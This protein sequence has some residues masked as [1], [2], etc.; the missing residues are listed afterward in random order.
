M[1]ADV[2]KGK[3]YFKDNDGNE[4][5]CDIH[6][7]RTNPDGTKIK[8]DQSDVNLQ[9]AD[10]FEVD[11]DKWDNT[12][13]PCIKDDDDGDGFPTKPAATLRTTKDLSIRRKKI[14]R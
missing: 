12:N 1:T 9:G 3:V 7:E 10:N 14:R 8:F 5:A 4:D 11:I 2:D 13:Q 6:L